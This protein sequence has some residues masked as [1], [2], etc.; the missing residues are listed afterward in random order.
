MWK[1]IKVVG[2]LLPLVNWWKLQ[3]IVCICFVFLEFCIN[4]GRSML[5]FSN[6]P[7]FK[8]I[9]LK[10]LWLFIKSNNQRSFKKKHYYFY[11][12][13]IFHTALT[14]DLRHVAWAYTNDNRGK[15]WLAAVNCEGSGLKLQEQRMQKMELPENQLYINANNT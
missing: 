5:F 6:E 7:R 10:M 13:L 9:T 1:G 2:V 14:V 11:F 3:R 8:I 15:R 4:A 12:L